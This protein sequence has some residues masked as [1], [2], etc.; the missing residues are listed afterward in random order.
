MF[1]TAD[2]PPPGSIWAL[3]LDHAGRLW[4]GNGHGGVARVDHPEADRPTFLTY[5][6]AQGLSSNEVQAIVEDS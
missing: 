1:T 6:T 4:V 3:Y 5:T 2:G